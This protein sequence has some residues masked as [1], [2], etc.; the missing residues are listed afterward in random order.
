MEAVTTAATWIKVIVLASLGCSSAWQ[1]SSG[2]TSLQPDQLNI[3]RYRL[4]TG[5]SLHSKY[6]GSG[7][8][9]AHSTRLWHSRHSLNKRMTPI[10]YMDYMDFSLAHKPKKK[11]IPM[12][13]WK[14]ESCS[15]WDVWRNARFLHSLVA[16]SEA[17]PHREALCH[18]GLT[19][20]NR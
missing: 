16:Y 7:S 10:D 19:T 12:S 9:E 18:D 5:P 4:R 6:R 14:D 13:S 11:V 3:C 8:A 1:T 20:K 15:V 2:V 17:R